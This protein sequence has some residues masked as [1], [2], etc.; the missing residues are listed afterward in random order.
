MSYFGCT[1]WRIVLTQV[2]GFCLSLF[3]CVYVC[4]HT[5]VYVCPG[6]YSQVCVA[7]LALRSSEH[8]HVFKFWPHSVLSCYLFPG[9]CCHFFPSFFFFWCI[10]RFHLM[11]T[12]QRSDS[13]GS[14]RCRLVNLSVWSSVLGSSSLLYVTFKWKGTSIKCFYTIS[15]QFLFLGFLCQL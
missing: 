13:A 14:L 7:Y 3:V 1:S 11:V 15:V 9:S 5:L 4:I 8:D 10:L 2:H 12:L 6:L